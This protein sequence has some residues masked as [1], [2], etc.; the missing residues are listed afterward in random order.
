MVDGSTGKGSSPLRANLIKKKEDITMEEH[1]WICDNCDER[2]A[3]HK[4]ELPQEHYASEMNKSKECP[5][6]GEDMY[7]DE[8]E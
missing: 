4:P 7:F 6:C 2:I 8:V 1:E 5:E 3:F